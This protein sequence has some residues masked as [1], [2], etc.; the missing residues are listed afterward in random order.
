MLGII[1]GVSIL[2]M[3]YAAA[4]TASATAYVPD[5]YPV[6]YV[7]AVATCGGS[8]MVSTTAVY[9]S[10]SGEYGMEGEGAIG[11]NYGSSFYGDGSVYVPGTPWLHIIGHQVNNADGTLN[12]A[13]TKTIAVF[14]ETW[15]KASAPSN[16]SSNGFGYI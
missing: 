1:F 7:T 14:G 6:Q 4:T 15:V 10:G 12:H 3:P 9:H 11:V 5:T 13:Y 8:N 2:V 16:P